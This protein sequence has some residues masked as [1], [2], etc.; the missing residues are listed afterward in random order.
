MEIRL[1]E[2]FQHLPSLTT[3]HRVTGFKRPVLILVWNTVITAARQDTCKTNKGEK[4]KDAHSLSCVHCESLTLTGK[5]WAIGTKHTAGRAIKSWHKI[6]A[7]ENC[8]YLGARNL[9]LF[10]KTKL[11]IQAVWPIH[12]QQNNTLIAQTPSQIS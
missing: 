10:C 4:A 1:A 7:L 6:P 11:R 2:I 3:E 12:S 8:I 5:P 9:S